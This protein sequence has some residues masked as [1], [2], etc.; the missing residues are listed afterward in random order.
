MKTRFLIVSILLVCL[1]TFLGAQEKFK[2]SIYDINIQQLNEKT[3]PNLAIEKEIVD[4]IPLKV[5]FYEKDGIKAGAEFTAVF[6]GRRMKLKRTLFVE[7]PD[8]KVVRSKQKK[9]VQLLKVSVSGSMKGR[10]AVEILY[11]RKKRKS[12]FIKYNYELIY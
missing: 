12:L 2:L 9:A 6:K 10:D 8:G 11:D 3:S 1:S 5:Q 4:G 7:T